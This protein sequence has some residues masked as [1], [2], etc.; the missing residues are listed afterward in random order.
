MIMCVA[1]LLY[2]NVNYY[3][4]PTYTGNLQVYQTKYASWKFSPSMKFIV[5]VM[6]YI[7]WLL[8]CIS[9]DDSGKI[10]LVMTKCCVLNIHNAL[11]KGRENKVS[12][13]SWQ[14]QTLLVVRGT[15]KCYTKYYPQIAPEVDVRRGCAIIR[16]WHLC[17]GYPV[18]SC[19]KNIIILT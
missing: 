19:K 1:C 18:E 13:F 7:P 2:T 17:I 16:Q 12:M 3:A 15:A 6:Y 10:M 5:R 8:A 14:Q 4:P 11:C 9:S